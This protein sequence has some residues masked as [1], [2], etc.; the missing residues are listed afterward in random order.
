[1]DD[2]T[3]FVQRS[4]SH[5]TRTP[6][7]PC[8][9]AGKGSDEDGISQSGAAAS[10]MQPF[11]LNRLPQRR[12]T[13]HRRS[14][15]SASRGTD[16][17]EAFMHLLRPLHLQE[18]LPEC[19]MLD[20]FVNQQRQLIC[21]GWQPELVLGNV[22]IDLDEVFVVAR[23]ESDPTTLN[24]YVTRTAMQHGS[25]GVPETCGLVT[26]ITRYLRWLIS[27]TSAHYERVPFFLRPT[28]AQMSI[29]HPSWIDLIL[30]P[31]IRDA[32]VTHPELRKP[33]WDARN[34]VAQFLNANWM[35]PPAQLF[36]P[37]YGSANL[38][39]TPLFESHILELNNWSID[40]DAA[41][42][43]PVLSAKVRSQPART[44]H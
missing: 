37:L 8:E 28:I 42:I 15:K 2:Q 9:P 39:L 5:T 41:S 12:E 1:M 21:D 19:Q 7:R 16:H 24:R 31:D 32:L 23:I 36:E 20:A 25:L 14:K 34:E 27:P 10:A 44:C 4:G 30:W 33:I 13:E 17:T 11:R 43:S 29:P 3:D 40:D 26:L 6:S 18:T 38:G 35:H 22:D